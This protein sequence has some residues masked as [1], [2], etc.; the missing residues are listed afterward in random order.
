MKTLFRYGIV[1]AGIILQSAAFA[2]SNSAYL[3][4]EKL[5]QL[6][7]VGTEAVTPDGKSVIYGVS[8]YTLSEN[9][10]NRDLYTVAVGGG[11]AQKLTT[12]PGNEV[13]ARLRPD[14]KKIGFLRGGNLWEMNLNGTDAKQ[15]SPDN[16]GAEG[17]EY[18]PANN[19]ILFPKTVAV[20]ENPYKKFFEGLPKANAHIADDLMY[21][22]WTEWDDYQ[23]SNIHYAPYDPEKGIT[24]EA[25]N[26]QNEPF[27]SPLQPNGGVE[28]IAWSAD[29][30]FIAY[31]CKKLAGKAY[32]I[33]TNSDI[34]LYEIATRQTRNISQENLGY[35]REPKFSPDGKYLAWGSVAEAAN[36]AGRNRLMVMELASGKKTELT[37]GFDD[38][39]NGAR[40]AADSKKLYFLSGVQATFQIFEA[41]VATRKLRQLTTGIHDFTSVFPLADGKTLIADRVSMS[42]PTEIFRVEIAT[43]A[44]TQLTFTNKALLEATP[45][46][47]VEPRTVKTTDGKDMRVWMIFPPNFDP[48]KKY[49]TLLYCQGGPQSALS[50][51][52]SYRWNFQLMAANGYIVVAPCRRGMPSFGTKWNDEISG[53]WGGQPMRDYLSATD[54]AAAQPYVDVARMGAVG[55]SYGGYSVYWLAGNHQKRF[56]AFIAH[57]GLY[58]MESWYTTTEEMFFA[59]NELRG[60]PWDAKKAPAYGKFSP[61]NFVG[62]WDTPI[63]VIHGEKDFRVPVQEGLQAFGAAQ[64]RGIPSRF[65]CFP[66][67]GH[68]VMSPQNGVLWHRVFFDWL[69]TNLKPKE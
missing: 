67:E 49:P 51:N 50:Q 26:I 10:G 27:D 45:F 32:A 55:A 20:G 41:D 36:E 57:C 40:W 47:K 29:G 54:Y 34:Y 56:K 39:A 28:E 6:G 3:T 22:H 46:G 60:T 65:L 25:I 14:G 37:E 9:K 16:L 53:D 13:N 61:H 48:A 59:N 24:G 64:L 31:T 62:N 17:F 38:E 15:V 66:D 12:F 8:Y 69:D 52:F 2:Q 11:E 43:G 21:R 33:S 4:P 30:K 5:W 35:D 63:L 18:S 7:R 58:N 42:Q 23:Y 19:A 44:M 68:W 1:A